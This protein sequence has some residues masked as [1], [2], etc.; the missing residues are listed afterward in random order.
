MMTIK[1][2]TGRD[3]SSGEPLKITIENGQIQ[4]I[5]PGPADESAWLSPGFIDLQVNGYLGSDLNSGTVDPEIVITL[6][7]KMIS[8]GVTTYLPTIITSSEERI[9]AALRAIAE[10]RRVSPIVAHAVPYVHLEGP[11]ISP[12]DGPRGAHAREHVRPPS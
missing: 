6:T 3:P 8:T 2:M 9:I 5:A 7:R 11:Y 1:S 10:A 4:S 12:Q